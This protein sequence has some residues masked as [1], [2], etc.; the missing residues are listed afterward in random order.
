[1]LQRLLLLRP[2][3]EAV[4]KDRSVTKKADKDIGLQPEQYGL[5]ESLINVLLQLERATTILSADKSVTISCAAFRFRTAG[6]LG[7]S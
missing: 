3:V 1:M 2:H 6:S 7:R 5:V 4:L